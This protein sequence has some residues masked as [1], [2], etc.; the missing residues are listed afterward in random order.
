MMSKGDQ[1]SIIPD[2]WTTLRR[3]TT[4]RI[5]LGR[6][7]GSLPTNEVLKFAMDHAAARDA[8]AAELDSD[9]LELE[10]QPLGLPIIRVESDAPDRLSYLQRPDLGRRLNDSSRSRLSPHPPGED[11][12]LLSPLPPGE[13]RVRVLSDSAYDL[14]LIIADGLSAFAT[15]TQSPPLL[16]ALLP[17]LQN[18]SHLALAPII[19]ARHARVAIEDEIGA[20]L[21]ARCAVILLGE[22]PGLGSADSLGAYLVYN[23]RVGNTDALRNCVSNIRDAGLKPID[24]A[25]TI[26]H[27]IVQSITRRLSGVGLKDDRMLTS[28]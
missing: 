15:I 26:H 21:N 16:R 4:A 1:S 7:G 8:V 12:P 11:S 9:E 28:G 2:P 13:G 17:M 18:E 3:H 22:R 5:A 10:L 14:V 6:A 24:A 27:L 25:R 23:P 19:L 20:I